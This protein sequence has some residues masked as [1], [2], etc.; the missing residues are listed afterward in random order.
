VVKAQVSTPLIPKP[1]IGHNPEPVQSTSHLTN[2]LPKIYP[3]GDGS[4]II[5]MLHLTKYYQGDKIG[6]MGGGCSMQVE[7]RYAYFL[8][9][10][11]E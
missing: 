8:V 7:M 5:C 2:C 9:G 6:E 1:T 11:S 10:K 4:F 3:N